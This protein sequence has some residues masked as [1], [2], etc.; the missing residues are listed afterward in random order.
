MG[1]SSFFAFVQPVAAQKLV[2]GD[3]NFSIS[4]SLNFSF[5]HSLNFSPRPA[6]FIRKALNTQAVS[7]LTKTREGLRFLQT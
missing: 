4:H 7:R 1:C 5:S 2:V 6:R 3:T